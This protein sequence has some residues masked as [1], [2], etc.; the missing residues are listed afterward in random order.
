VRSPSRNAPCSRVNLERDRHRAH[1]DGWSSQVPDT[2]RACRL[3]GAWHFTAWQRGSS[4]AV[5]AA[6]Y[7]DALT[8]SGAPQHPGQ[9]TAQSASTVHTRSGAPAAVNF[10]RQRSTDA[11]IVPPVRRS[12]SIASRALRFSRSNCS[13]SASVVRTGTGGALAVGA[14]SAVGAAGKAPGLG[15]LAHPTSSTRCARATG[16]FWQAS[17][18]VKADMSSAASLDDPRPVT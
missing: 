6:P 17:R 11:S 2:H 1:P 7:V 18:K 16:A 15:G 14:G 13:T 3:A 12:A 8:G 4:M 9:R 10:R 5:T